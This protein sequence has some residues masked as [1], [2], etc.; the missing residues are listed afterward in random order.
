MS[1]KKKNTTPW[2][3]EKQEKILGAKGGSWRSK[4]MET[5]V[6]QL[7]IKEYKLSSTSQFTVQLTLIIYTSHA[8][9][10]IAEAVYT[11]RFKHMQTRWCHLF[12]VFVDVA[13]RFNWR[14]ESKHVMQ[15]K[16]IN[17]ALNRCIPGDVNCS[18]TSLV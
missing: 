4:K 16:G 2:Q 8:V 17:L 13:A 11:S 5:R 6:Y 14:W 3:Y 1:K 15:R 9:Q 12:R 18:E 7:N 10:L